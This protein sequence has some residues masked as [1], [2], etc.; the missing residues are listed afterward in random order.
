MVK[1]WQ[2]S[3]DRNF[4]IVLYYGNNF[5]YGLT[6]VRCTSLWYNTM[7][8]VYYYGLTIVSCTL[9][10]YI[11]MVYYMLL[12]SYHSKMY[13]TMVLYHGICTLLW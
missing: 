3:G 8:L 10:W 9:L 4:T 13:F 12:W 6:I 2:S 1:L 5:Y 7:V 11:T